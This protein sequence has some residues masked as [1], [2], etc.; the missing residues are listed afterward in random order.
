[1]L[2][3]Y[4]RDYN[5]ILSLKRALCEVYNLKLKRNVREPEQPEAGEKADRS[6]QKQTEAESEQMRAERKQER[7]RESIREAREMIRSLAGEQG[8]REF[9]QPSVTWH[10]YLGVYIL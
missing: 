9:S 4:L 6:R 2:Y 1:M 8:R 3:L 7:A 5:E 10:L